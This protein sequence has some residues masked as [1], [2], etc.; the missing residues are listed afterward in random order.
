[1]W[2]KHSEEPEITCAELGRA[3]SSAIA[4]VTDGLQILRDCLK[5]IE[6]VGAALLARG[7]DPYKLGV[8]GKE[9][10]LGH[11][12]GVLYALIEAEVRL[13]GICQALDDRR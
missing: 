4:P 10:I 7:D 6:R 5:E 8:K 9:D 13:K 11:I 1:M 2:G 12:A 3:V